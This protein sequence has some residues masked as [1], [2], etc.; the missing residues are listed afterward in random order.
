MIFTDSLLIALYARLSKDRSGLSENV[1]IQIAEGDDFVEE[2]GGMVAL[3]FKDNDISIS[4]FSKKPRPDYDR[5]IAAIEGGKVEIIVATEMT[6]LYRRLDELL[7][8]I[9]MA[10]TTRLRGIWTTDGVGYD[11]STP[12]GIHAAIAAVNNAMLESAKISKR[13]RRKQGAR[14]KNGK[15][16]GGVRSY[17]YEPPIKDE[18][19]NLLNKATLNT[20]LVDHEVAVFESNVDKLVAGE[21]ATWIVRDLNSRGIPAAAGG[22][23]TASNFQRLMTKKRYVIFDD[24]DPEKRGICEYNGVEFRAE[25]KGIISRATHAQMVAQFQKRA[26]P[27]A[28]DET[29]GRGYLLT[30]LIECGVCGV[31]ASG[32]G[33]YLKSGVFQRRYGCHPTYNAG[34]PKGCG[35][36][37]RGAD[38]I[39]ALVTEFVLQRL[40]TPEIGRL[41]AD[42]N[43]N[44]ELIDKLLKELTHMQAHR[45]NLVREYGLGE[46]EKA[47]YTTMLASADQAIEDLND[48][49]S[50]LYDPQVSALLPSGQPVRELW[51][52][53]SL[54]WQRSVVKLVVKKVVIHPCSGAVQHWRGWRFELDSV[55][56]VARC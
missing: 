29:L 31:G 53:A 19:G 40:D 42:S 41:L 48:K 34:T 15:H 51:E 12:E 18:H 9:K 47:D 10:E 54:D 30:G 38:P 46:H 4:K 16:H 6:R 36:I 17:C 49:L 26:R 50:P 3:R 22:D 25:W 13:T 24:E 28:R 23:W 1:G 7:G 33:R 27:W 35:H 20:A 56:L 39:D 14:A 21:R 11:L 37:Y 52:N 32:G 5:L 8:L 2:N 45:Q 55:E 43:D 44:Q